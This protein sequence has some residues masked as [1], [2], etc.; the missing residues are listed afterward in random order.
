MAQAAV[1]TVI[2]ANGKV[3]SS[4]VGAKSAPARPENVK[5]TETDDR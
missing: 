5:T 2:K 1:T 4:G 3:A